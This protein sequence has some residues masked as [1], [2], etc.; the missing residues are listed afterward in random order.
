MTWEKATLLWL[1]EQIA[2]NW[3][4]RSCSYWFGRCEIVPFH[5]RTWGERLLPEQIKETL[6]SQRIISCTCFYRLG[7]AQYLAD[8]FCSCFVR[9][10]ASHGCKDRS[11]IFLF[12]LLHPRLLRCY[13]FLWNSSVNLYSPPQK[14]DHAEQE[15]ADL[16]IELFCLNHLQ[17]TSER[18]AIDESV[19]SQKWTKCHICVE[20]R[21]TKSV[22]KEKRTFVFQKAYSSFTK[23]L[24]SYCSVP[25]LLRSVAS[26]DWK[27]NCSENS[28][29]FEAEKARLK[30]KDNM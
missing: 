26:L 14:C 2:E 11:K 20:R 25:R 8:L 27:K 16:L 13:K 22:K 1:S 9:K 21:W 29:K 17:E 30:N 10:K 23:R 18:S 12:S 7:G 6:S 19:S 3:S 15:N 5:W 28:Y 4:L 24:Q